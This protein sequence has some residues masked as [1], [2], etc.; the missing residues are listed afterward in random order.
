MPD[1]LEKEV[2]SEILQFG[3]SPFFPNKEK[4]IPS[5]F[6]NEMKQLVGTVES[7]ILGKPS[8]Y[9]LIVTTFR[10]ILYRYNKRK[11][12]LVLS[13]WF[14]LDLTEKSFP[15]E[16]GF[17]ITKVETTMPEYGFDETHHRPFFTWESNC[18][19]A[20]AEKKNVATVKV[21]PVKY[22]YHQK[23]QYVDAMKPISI[24]GFTY[25]ENET[26]F[27]YIPFSVKFFIIKRGPMGILK[28]ADL[29]LLHKDPQL[30]GFHSAGEVPEDCPMHED[31]AT[32][33]RESFAVNSKA[34]KGTSKKRKLSWK[35]A[36][37]TAI[38][39]GSRV[40]SG[41]DLAEKAAN[42]VNA[43]KDTSL[44]T[45]RSTPKSVRSEK[46]LTEKN[47][48]T[49]TQ[50]GRFCLACGAIMRPGAVFCGKCGKKIAD[51]VIETAKD[52]VS[53]K[54]E[55]EVIEKT[56]DLLEDKQMVPKNQD[57]R[58]IAIKNSGL[59]SNIIKVLNDG[60]Y[61]TLGELADQVSSDVN[62]IT[63]LNGIGPASIKKIYKR[64][65]DIPAHPK[66]DTNSSKLKSRKCA[67]CGNILDS[68]W[69]FCPFCQQPLQQLCT[70]CGYQ[71][72]P[73]WSF[74]PMCNKQL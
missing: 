29:M 47:N 10:I 19:N 53:G 59:A 67:N 6:H 68:D 57:P 5:L 2:R 72:E 65:S 55:D 26:Y 56:K 13:F 63:S 40:K 48:P 11:D 37:S 58:D 1:K 38:E 60:G 32:R 7:A 51:Q 33:A 70:Q 14:N 4:P 30:A 44:N 15:D 25:Q 61:Y 41:L 64:L 36:A 52:K 66:S 18:F 31:T 69:K 45:N 24:P 23:K 50:D 42:T 17:H 8:I 3:P 39:V 49:H 74:C 54:L 9:F 34:K 20:K 22:Y 16:K 46:T 71:I 35:K 21:V 28:M 27:G 73:G 62:K 12:D 43:L